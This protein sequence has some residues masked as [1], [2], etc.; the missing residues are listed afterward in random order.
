[1][2]IVACN[3]VRCSKVKSWLPKIVL[4]SSARFFVAATLLAL[5]AIARADG[6][7]RE[8]AAIYLDD[9]FGRPYRLQVLTD[10]PIYFNADA[11]RFLGTLRRGQLVE[12]QAVSENQGV[13]RVRGQANQGQVAGWVPA[14]YLSPLEQGFVDALRRSG[15]RRK[16]VVALTANGEVALGMTPPEVV[17]SVG[18]PSK[19]SSHTDV[20]GVAETWDYV[21]YEQVA[22]SVPGVDAF[23]RV[24]VNVVYERVPVGRFSVTFTGGLV[25]AIDQSDRVANTAVPPVKVVPPPVVF[26][27]GD[28]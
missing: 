25:S 20:Q 18:Q 9:F 27:R 6:L 15:E 7:P 5:P 14:R 2:V 10:A 28:S 1:M 19:K 8:K 11:A 26:G 17:A 13:L 22:R 16:Q 21:R 3:V 12:L 23:G 4:L 24:V